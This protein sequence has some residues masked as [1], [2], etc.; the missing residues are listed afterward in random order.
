M[1]SNKTSIAKHIIIGLLVIGLVYWVIVNP[2]IDLPTITQAG[3]FIFSG[4]IYLLTQIKSLRNI[5]FLGWFL[6]VTGGI[7]SM[8][9]WTEIVM[10]VIESKW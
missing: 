1:K 9:L 5:S 10:T 2:L 3:I 8:A 4:A 7:I 6:I